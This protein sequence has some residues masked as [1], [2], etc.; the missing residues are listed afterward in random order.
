[1][2]QFPSFVDSLPITRRALEYASEH[3]EGQRRTS[4]DAA[5][6]LHPLEVAQLLRGRGYRDEVV[7]AG[8]LHDSLE[9]TDAT[10]LELE[11][12]FGPAVAALV[13]SVSEPSAGGTYAQRKAR[14]RASLLHAGPDSLAVYAADKVA[15]V[16]ELRMTLARDWSAAVNPGTADKLHHYWASLTLLESLVD[17]DPFVDQLRFELEAL[18]TLPP[19][20]PGTLPVSSPERTPAPAATPP[21]PHV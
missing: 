15:K 4:D 11:Q 2:L 1:M 7:A 3:H 14:L 5:F 6:I 9:D 17:D 16:R 19:R 10:P 20:T 13:C 21:T 8:V 18:A 12:R